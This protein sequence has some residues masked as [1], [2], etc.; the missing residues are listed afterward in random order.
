MNKKILIVCMSCFLSNFSYALALPQATSF[1]QRMQEVTYN[2]DDSV[3]VKIKAGT[4]TL[5]QLEKGEYITDEVAGIVL[6]DPDA[7]DVNVRGNNIYFRP[8]KDEPDTNVTLT[9]NI[10]TYVLYLKSVKVDP[11]W[12]VRFK[13][14]KKH[15]S[16][17]QNLFS[18]TP[19]QSN[20]E[21]NANWDYQI[22]GKESF[23][24]YE[25]WDDGRFTCF[26]FNPSSDLP[27]IYRVAGD[28]SEMLVN[29]NIED[30]ITVVQETSSMFRIRLGSKVVAV[31][32]NISLPA[33]SNATGTT[34]GKIR[35]IKSDE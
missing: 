1:D 35:E 13:Y 20:G 27:M 34:N 9:S 11:S 6:G 17:S 25:V 32:T 4:S 7:W 15:N 5:V 33:P 29:S 21:F 22:L 24:P 26:R 14:P 31:R 23:Q 18:K 19:C 28:G 30:N 8:I 2:P 16:K 10:R 12:M 3:L